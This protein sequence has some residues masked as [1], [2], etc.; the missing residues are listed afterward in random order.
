MW[1]AACATKSSG[2]GTLLIDY[3]A[4]PENPTLNT[5]STRDDFAHCLA[6]HG[7]LGQRAVAHSLHYFEAPWLVVCVVREGFVGVSWHGWRGVFDYGR[8]I[9]YHFMHTFAERRSAKFTACPLT[10]FISK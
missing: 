8:D 7:I 3:R 6:C 1:F 2:C 10:A 5:H 9:V 4:A